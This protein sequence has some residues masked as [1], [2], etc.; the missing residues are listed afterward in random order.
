MFKIL[1]YNFRAH[2]LVPLIVAQLY[3]KSRALA[4]GL[5]KTAMELVLY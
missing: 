2:F 3:Q 5:K 1:A 4:T